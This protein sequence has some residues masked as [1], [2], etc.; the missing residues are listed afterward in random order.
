MKKAIL[1]HTQKQRRWHIFILLKWCSQLTFKHRLFNICILSKNW[2]H[3]HQNCTQWKFE[4]GAR[5]ISSSQ[6]A[7]CRWCPKRTFPFITWY[8][9]MQGYINYVCCYEVFISC[10]HELYIEWFCINGG[11]LFK[12]EEKQNG[13]IQT[14]DLLMKSKT[15]STDQSLRS[16]FPTVV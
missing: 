15:I 2:T 10:G 7:L 6:G 13:K 4:Y 16:D 5:T 3:G 14:N 11:W 1:L 12:K 8:Y 9:V